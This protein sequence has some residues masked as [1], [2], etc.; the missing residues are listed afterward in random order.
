[1]I[2]EWYDQFFWIYF[3]DLFCYTEQ[4][5]KKF[6]GFFETKGR[7][8]NQFWTPHSWKQFWRTRGKYNLR[9]KGLWCRCMQWTS[10]SRKEKILSQDRYIHPDRFW[11]LFSL[12]LTLLHHNLCCYLWR[13]PS[14]CHWILIMT[15]HLTCRPC[16]N[17]S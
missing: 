11:S 1:M 5:Y 10:T 7:P 14:W 4:I 2:L 17:K 6:H 8:W 9:L 16:G 12:F 3:T 15:L 13:F